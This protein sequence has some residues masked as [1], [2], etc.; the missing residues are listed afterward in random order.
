MLTVRELLDR[1]S[2]ADLLTSLGG[3]PVGSGH[4]ARWPCI[5]P[6]H[7]DAH[8][9]VTMFTDRRGVERWRCWS[10]GRNGTAIDAVMVAHRLG[11]GDA[12]RWL[13]EH[14]GNLPPAEHRPTTTQQH[15]DLSNSL[16]R[17]VHDCEHRLWQPAGRRGLN[18]LHARGLD[19]AVLEAN[20]VGYNLARPT[21]R[22]IRLTDFTGVTVCSFDRRG[23][24]A[25]VQLRILDATGRGKY[26]NPA[27][28]PI[29]AVSYP[30]GG[31]IGGPLVVAEGVLDGLVVT[32]A[33]FRCAALS[34]ASSVPWAKTSTVAEQI[35]AH[36]AGQ[37]IVIAL[38]G[39]R[40]GRA[41]AR[42]LYHQLDGHDVRLL[43][44][45]DDHDLTTL[46]RKKAPAWQHHPS[47]SQAP[48]VSSIA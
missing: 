20:R 11:T 3:P 16:R 46:Y 21:A 47:S 5:A 27:K 2:L 25:Y 33:G 8:P 38:D 41:A 1:T 10:D 32:Q 29:P 22:P 6:D 45:P 36:A 30:R 24:L 42:R 13:A 31:P 26:K 17:W 18:W 48:N 44:L 15:R 14:Y 34:S 39:D 19:D 40:D 7:D 23:E 9:S 28:V 12:M 37:Q 43:D 35:A 4:H